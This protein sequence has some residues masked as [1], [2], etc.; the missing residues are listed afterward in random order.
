MPGGNGRGFHFAP[1]F[2]DR[3]HGTLSRGHENVALRPKTWTLLCYL[4]ERPGHLATKAELLDALWPDAAVNESAVA[5]CISELRAAL[6]D[7]PRKP[8]YIE[9]AHRRGYRWI[10]PVQQQGGDLPS[11]A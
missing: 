1:F 5:N 2:L 8:R 7:D 9:I 4:L 11:V 10:A 6:G 3:D